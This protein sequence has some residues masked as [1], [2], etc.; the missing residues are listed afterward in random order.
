M[1]TINEIVKMMNDHPNLKFRIEGHTDNDGD[2]AYNQKLSEQRAY[3][4]KSMLV[5][6]GISAARL[7][8]KGYGETKPVDDNSTPEGKANNRRVVSFIKI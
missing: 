4:V 6:S 1:R 2:D 5:N 7:E 8:T 3:A